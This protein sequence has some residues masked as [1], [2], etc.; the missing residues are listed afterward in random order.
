MKSCFIDTSGIL[1]ALDKTDENHS[2]A[3]VILEKLIGE[4]YSLISSSYV[5]L[6]LAALIQHR[7]GMEALQTFHNDLYPLLKIEWIDE[8]IH[9]TALMAVLAMGR[10]KLSLVDC[11]S[12]EVMRKYSLKNVFTF[13]KHF[14]EQGFTLL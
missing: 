7:L 8:N 11:I 3:R 2:K 12:F 9:N 14:K 5:L 6:E 1:A 4:D 13:D 10:K